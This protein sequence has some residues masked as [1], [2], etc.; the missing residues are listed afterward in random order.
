MGQKVP[1]VVASA[2]GRRVRRIRKCLMDRKSADGRRIR[3]RVSRPKD[4][5]VQRSSRPQ[6][7]VASEDK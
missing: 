1:T 4:K 7:V 2:S 5:K 6:A 3:K